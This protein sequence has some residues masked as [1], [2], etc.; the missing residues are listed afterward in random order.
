MNK[1]LT[2]I[3]LLM[4]LTTSSQ[5]FS[6]ENKHVV[7][8]L[9]RGVTDAEK[10]FMEYLS[11]RIDVDFTI[12]DAERDKEQLYKNIH[13][14][15]S[16][17]VDLVY[18][19]GTTITRTLLG[20]VDEP[21]EFRYSNIPVVFSIVSDPVGSKIISNQ[22]DKR[23]FTGVSHIVPHH[24]QLKSISKL[25]NID[26][27]GILY[28]PLENN[29]VVTAKK[30]SALSD[31]F[32]KDIVLYPFSIEQGRPDIN[33]ID[34]IVSNMLS[35]GIDLAYL[36]PDSFVISSSKAIV[37]SM[38]NE[39]IATFSSTEAP[40]R[41]GQALIGIVSR[42][43]NVGQFAAYKAEQVLNSNINI[44]NIPIESLSQY[45]YIVNIDAAK[46]LNYYPPVS[47]LKI[48][49]LIGNNTDG[50]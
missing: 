47:V 16:M 20:T 1:V 31:Y 29:S 39:G 28:N 36:P 13:S 33:S 50:N 25:A 4:T 19:F 46:H 5:A 9:W 3:L 18:T 41:N 24:V 30:I 15:E 48:S 37:R 14:L 23:N 38:H 45:S 35:D 43:Y 21:T 2:F 42:Y 22:S 17:D 40:I 10:G 27:I 44:N 26:S 32:N 34:N 7:M 12:L 6:A 49:E 11:K 8:L